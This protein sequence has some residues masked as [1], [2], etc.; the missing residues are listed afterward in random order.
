MCVYVYVFRYFTVVFCLSVLFYYTVV[1]VFF[2]IF[3]LECLV[4]VSL[5]DYIWIGLPV[6]PSSFRCLFSCTMSLCVLSS[7]LNPA[8]LYLYCVNLYVSAS[9]SPPIVCLFVCVDLIRTSLVSYPSSIHPCCFDS[10]L[11]L[12]FCFLHSACSCVT[13][14]VS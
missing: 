9:V 11:P 10:A 4:L 1:V 5:F 3:R 13:V 6:S 12:S 2:Y 7:L 14:P 8:C